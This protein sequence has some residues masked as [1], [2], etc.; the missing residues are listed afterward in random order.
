LGASLGP[1]PLQT[2]S[3]RLHKGRKPESLTL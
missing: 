2:A 3:T 1:M